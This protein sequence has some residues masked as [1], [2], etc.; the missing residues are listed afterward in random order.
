M[1][2]WI[3]TLL[4]SALHGIVQAFP[5]IGIILGGISAIL[6]GIILIYTLVPGPQPEQ[7]L[8]S[9]VDFITRISRK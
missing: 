6:T 1:A 4:E 8:Q 3:L 5:F 2:S 7:F 9:V